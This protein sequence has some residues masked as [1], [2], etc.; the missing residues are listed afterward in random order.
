LCSGNYVGFINAG[1]YSHTT[2]MEELATASITKT[3][4]YTTGPVD[5][6]S[7]SGIKEEVFFPFERFASRKVYVYSMITAHQSFYISRDLIKSIGLFDLRYSLRSDFDMV[8]RAV[9]SGQQHYQFERSV[10]A[11][12]R[13]GVS[14][15]YE[16]F[17]ENF[18]L[19][20]SHDGRLFKIICV[21]VF[22]L[23]KVFVARNFPSAV[24]S[25]LRKYFSSG[26]YIT[27][28]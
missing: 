19:M 20:R 4:G 3:F 6:I 7:E 12:R 23:S 14:G 13:G 8:I 25:L 2:T 15:G 24:S 16:T 22:S 17:F 9:S 11:F 27:S 21:T 5:I 1:D 28:K 18:R 10:G 26:R